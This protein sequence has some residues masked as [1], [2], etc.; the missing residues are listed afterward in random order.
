MLSIRIYDVRGRLIRRLV[1][2]EPGSSRE[3]IAWDGRDDEHQKAR[4]GMYI[5]LLEALNA[6]GGML[7]SAKG[8]VVLAGRL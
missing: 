5:V 1:N 3:D 6:G 4:I 8:V 2:N 7:E